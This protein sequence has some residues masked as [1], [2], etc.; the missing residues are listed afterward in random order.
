MNH[1]CACVWLYL[2]F[3][4]DCVGKVACT[5]SWIYETEFH[6]KPIKT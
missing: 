1:L 5:K 6:E 4:E 2:G 3:Q